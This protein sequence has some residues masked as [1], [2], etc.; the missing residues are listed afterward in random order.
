VI[1]AY[2]KAAGANTF[3]GAA[4][5]FTRSGTVWS[6]QQKLTASDGSNS[7]LFGYSVS[8]SVDTV[9][10]GAW[11]KT[12]GANNAQGAAYVFTRS[13]TVWSQQQ[14][15]TASDGAA[16][17]QFGVSVS[18]NGNTVVISANTKAVGAN[19]AQGAAYVFVGPA[20]ATGLQFVP[21]TPCRVVDTRASQNFAS[22]FGTPSLVG[23]GFTLS[24]GPTRTFPIPTSTHC[25]IPANAQAYSFNVTVIPPGSLGFLTLFPTGQA[26]PNAVT[27]DDTQGLILNNAAI[28]PAGTNGSV[29][30]F[31]SDNTDLAI[32]ING[33]FVPSTPSSLVFVPMTPCRVV[34]TR[35]SQN[36]MSP[37]G[38]PS[39]V[40]GGFTL[41]GGPTRTF[42]I[43]SSPNCMIP[44]NAM[45]YSF[46]VTVI[47][48]GPLGFLVIFP[49]GQPR[50]N[51]VTLDDTQG[52]IL[53]NS[54]IVPAGTNGS[55]D[56]FASQN[57][58]LTIDINGYY[59]LSSPSGL[60]FV[61][62][63]PCRVVDL[64]SELRNSFEC[65]GV[66]G[67]RDSRSAGA[68]GILGHMAHWAIAPQCRDVG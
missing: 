63:T 11:Q 26:R 25:T 27:I 38:A 14:K 57:T 2:A 34:D 47:P 28:V 20:I 40:G 50:P 30:V 51:A 48:P 58:D 46:N 9:A 33:Y 41:S 15:L 45:A 19:S 7:D 23:G 24:G 52:V 54:A 8:V 1:G 55:V 37:F 42:Q 59:V 49:T 21:I 32:D 36:F 31:A 13:G 5:V 61:P 17:D 16:S 62:M 60:V 6:Q 10:I 53:N 18:V 68:A 3:Q 39:L 22:P 66:F 12:V 4:Y 35:A 67:Q 29:D 65:V 64:Q 43:P 56:V 44:S